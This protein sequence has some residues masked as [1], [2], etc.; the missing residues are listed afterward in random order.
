[1]LLVVLVQWMGLTFIASNVK[2]QPPST[3]GRRNRENIGVDAKNYPEVLQF[4]K[5]LLLNSV[6]GISEFNKRINAACFNIDL[7]IS[8]HESTTSSTLLHNY[9]GRVFIK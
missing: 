3:A 4:M 2:K 9:I 6:I 1:M 5:A 7:S 8:K